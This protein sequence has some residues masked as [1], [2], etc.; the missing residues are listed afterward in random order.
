MVGS[1]MISTDNEIGDLIPIT[2]ASSWHDSISINENLSARDTISSCRL[3][4]RHG[5]CPLPYRTIHK[6]PARLSNAL[7][8]QLLRFALVPPNVTIG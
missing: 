2:E 1:S 3:H 6:T 5:L 4:G 8:S 7:R